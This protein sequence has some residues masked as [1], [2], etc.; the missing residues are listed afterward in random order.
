MS[1]LVALRGGVAMGQGG[2][3]ERKQQPLGFGHVAGQG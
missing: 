2:S 1:G 3:G